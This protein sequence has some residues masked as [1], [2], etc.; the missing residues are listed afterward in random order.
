MTGQT[1]K[2]TMK[3]DWIEPGVLAASAIP[4]D[5]V[6]IRSLHEQGIRA[7]VTL[8]EK[9]LLVWRG[10]PP[11]IFEEL[12]ITAHHFP[13]PDGKPPEMEQAKEILAFMDKMTAEGR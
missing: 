4:V 7:I 3:M 11:G 6:D 5:A 10:I 13:I 9:P 12:D 2:L 8:T 1:D